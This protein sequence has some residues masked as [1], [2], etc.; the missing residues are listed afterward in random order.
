MNKFLKKKLKTKKRIILRTNLCQE[1]ILMNF[2]KLKEENNAGKDLWKL[3]EI[4]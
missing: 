3:K 4:K 2:L 1:G